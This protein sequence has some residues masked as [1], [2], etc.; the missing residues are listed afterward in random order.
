MSGKWSHLQLGLD[1][2]AMQELEKNSKN[3][4]SIFLHHGVPPSVVGYGTSNYA[5][6]RQE[7]ISFRR[8]TVLPLLNLFADTMNSD[9]GFITSFTEDLRLDFS[10]TGLLDVEQIMRESTP[11]FDRGGLTPNDMREAA[12]LPRVDNELLDQYYIPS[13]YVPLEIAGVAAPTD[14]QMGAPP[15]PPA[16][17]PSS[18]PAAADQTTTNGIPARTPGKPKPPKP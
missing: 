9:R 16:A 11:L 13:G 18:K 3:V 1:S 2:V 17:P 6:A 12:G 14:A 4:E 10:L 7:D 8:Y 5:T 15:I